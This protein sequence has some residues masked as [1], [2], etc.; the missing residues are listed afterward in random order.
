MKEQWVSIKG[1]GGKYLISNFGRMKS[2]GGKFK[3]R[4][5]D[6]YITIGSI[7]T[8]GYRVIT[9]RSPGRV[10]Q[11]RVHSLV[12][13]AFLTKPDT[14]NTY[15]VNHKDG[16]KLNNNL[17]NLEWVTPKGNADHAVITG[18]HDLKGEKHPMS[19]LTK[20]NVLE[21]RRLRKEGFTHEKIASMFG[22]C[23]R[24]AGDVINGVNWGW[25]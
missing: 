2:I 10:E 14:E 20:E 21:M 4:C 3:T 25:I 18:L 5:P 6:G 23:R 9:M 22:V 24:Q 16:N 7:D 15:W 11:K 17:D 13:S 8:L 12:A 1:W 19:K